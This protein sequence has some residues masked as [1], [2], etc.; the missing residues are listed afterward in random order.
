MKKM[1]RFYL[2]EIIKW[3]Y[4]QYYQLLKRQKK[5]LKYDILFCEDFLDSSVAIRNKFSN[6]KIAVVDL[7]QMSNWEILKMISVSKL[8]YTDNLHLTLSS[9]KQNKP[10]Y[11]LYWHASSAVKQFGL[12]TITS[13]N[14]LKVRKKEYKR[15]DY[16]TINSNY[17]ADICK[18]ALA[19]EDEQLIKSG[20]NAS[21]LYYQSNFEANKG[22]LQQ[23]LGIFK[24]QY[25]IYAPTFR[26]DSNSSQ[27]QIEFIENYKHSTL[28]LVYSIHQLTSVS[29]E[30]KSAI[31]ASSYDIR[32]LLDDAALIISDYSSLLIDGI[33][34]NGSVVAYAYDYDQYAKNPGLFL[35]LDQLGMCIFKCGEKLHEYIEQEEYNKVYTRT[36]YFEFDS[37][38]NTDNIAKVGKEKLCSF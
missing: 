3:V 31:D 13:E 9:I 34:R 16:M 6:A 24:Q 4:N 27:E 2:R 19:M 12:P 36:N 32:L 10:T 22:E 26:V 30:N 14:E 20:M 38:D 5:S 21:S 17:M 23:Q 1:C 37:I 15:Y 28:K 8:V 25:I 35:E 18:K 11:I 33:M 7:K 29:I